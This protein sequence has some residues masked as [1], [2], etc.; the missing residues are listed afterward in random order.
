MAVSDFAT[1]PAAASYLLSNATLPA[2]LVSDVKLPAGAE[3]VRADIEVRD[4]RI[5]A[6]ASLGPTSLPSVAHEAQ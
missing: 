6:I 2:A 5:A 3:L 4:G 1:I